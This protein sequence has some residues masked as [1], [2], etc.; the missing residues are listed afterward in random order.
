MILRLEQEKKTAL[1]EMMTNLQTEVKDKE[2]TQQEL[3][4]VKEVQFTAMKNG[5]TK[6]LYLLARDN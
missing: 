5:G 6:A 2:D 1:Q 4:T 3:N